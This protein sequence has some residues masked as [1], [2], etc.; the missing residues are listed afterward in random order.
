MEEE[1]EDDDDEEEEEEERRRPVCCPKAHRH[2]HR[3]RKKQNKRRT[4]SYRV[5][6]LFLF[7]TEFSFFFLSYQTK[8]IKERF[9]VDWETRWYFLFCCSFDFSLVCGGL[10]TFGIDQFRLFLR[11]TRRVEAIGMLMKSAPSSFSSS[12]SSSSSSSFSFHLFT[13]SRWSVLFCYFFFLFFTFFLP[14]VS[15][16]TRFF[17]LFSRLTPYCLRTSGSC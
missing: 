16:A 12:S 7:P 9:G 14:S 11:P 17:F 5:F 13:C 8:E 3:R 6:L 15:F 4:I 10:N 1:E 2:R